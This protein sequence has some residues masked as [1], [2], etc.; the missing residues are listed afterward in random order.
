MSESIDRKA[1]WETHVE[2]GE[3]ER[4]L[5]PWGKNGVWVDEVWDYVLRAALKRI[6]IAMAEGDYPSLLII[7]RHEDL[8]VKTRKLAA[9]ALIPSIRNA[10]RLFHQMHR[11][12]RLEEIS[13]S[14]I[15]PEDLRRMAGIQAVTGFSETAAY[16]PL[17]HMA[18]R[19]SH[20]EDVRL[21]ADQALALAIGK[22]H[23]DKNRRAAYKKL[24]EIAHDPDCSR[25]VRIQVQETLETV[26]R[27]LAE[28]LLEKEEENALL[29]MGKEELLSVPLREHI[30]IKLVESWKTKGKFEHLFEMMEDRHLPDRVR[31]YA[32][33]AVG[34]SVQNYLEKDSNKQNHLELLRISA[35]RRIP[36]AVRESAG[37]QAVDR[38][39]AN[40]DRFSLLKIM[41][42]E[43]RLQPIRKHAFLAYI[44]LLAERGNCID[45]LTHYDET[46][47]TDTRKAIWDVFPQSLEV[48]LRNLA[49]KGSIAECLLLTGDSRLT[50][51]MREQL[52][53]ALL[54]LCR[55]KG[56]EQPL[57]ELASNPNLS[58]T[59]RIGA[60]RSAVS[61][62]QRTGSIDRLRSISSSSHYPAEVRHTAQDAWQQGMDRYF[63]QLCRNKEAEK[64]YHL[65]K[66]HQVEEALRIEA[67]LASVDLY[68]RRPLTG[69][70]FL[71]LMA[72]D[73]GL[74]QEVS[75]A[76]E[77]AAQ[78][79]A[80]FYKKRK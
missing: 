27:G 38:L 64:L 16:R 41:Q 8:P 52:G 69:P 58:E 67:G 48:F 42:D 46:L 33:E 71:S 59:L 80:A 14:S 44:S 1:V 73:K 65:A 60:G 4:L 79:L 62:L 57:L 18:N 34:E 50:Q 5:D 53:T 7:Q 66:D 55:Q 23:T 3:Y 75:Q 13:S 36:P 56:Q 22:I 74:H 68:G 72:E 12:D 6:S 19:L 77:K 20:P 28:D 26:G 25:K 24:R 15:F 49:Q 61:C 78:Q 31:L 17:L 37:K 76:A 45:L 47:D 35:F 30:G 54:D 43:S 40:K 29:D 63:D 21:Q 32:E 51:E 39:S 11:Y 10:I 70:A 2:R 9:A